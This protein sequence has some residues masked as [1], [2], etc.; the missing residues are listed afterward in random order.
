MLA[1]V[2]RE[3]QALDASL[4]LYNVKTLEE[5]KSGSVYTSRMAATLLTVF[6]LL[7]LGLAA[8][9]L[10]GVMA[11]AV[12]RRMRELGI[13]MA[14]GA[15]AGN[16]LKLILM[17]GL[18]LALIG[19]GI[20]LL[21]A[22]ALTHWIESMLFGVRPADPLTFTTIAVGLTLVALVACYIPARRATKVDPLTALRHE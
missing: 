4:P 15:Q 5:Q 19:V 14:L 13:R 3:A 12:N 17:Q 6:G 1:A 22:F 20:G 2:R 8:M 21:A 11:H 16:V 9:G 10:Y 7:A 18:M